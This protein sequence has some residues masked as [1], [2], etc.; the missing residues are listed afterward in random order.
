[1][2]KLKAGYRDMNN[3]RSTAGDET[4]DCIQSLSTEVDTIV[5]YP[6]DI[7][8]KRRIVKVVSISDNN[9]KDHSERMRKARSE[10]GGALLMLQIQC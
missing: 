7:K 1:V 2:L 3:D 4:C 8:N 10:N 5:G 9:I 6:I